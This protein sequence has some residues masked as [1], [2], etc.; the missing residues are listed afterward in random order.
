MP[1]LTVTLPAGDLAKRIADL[2]ALVL[3]LLARIQALE[4]LDTVLEEVGQKLPRCLCSRRERQK[5]GAARC[6][7]VPPRAPGRGAQTTAGFTFSAY[8]ESSGRWCR[9]TQIC[10]GGSDSLDSMVSRNLRTCWKRPAVSTE[11]F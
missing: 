3:A 9:R 7:R 6:A 5:Q 4:E 8:P 1:S 10:M 2:E 11:K